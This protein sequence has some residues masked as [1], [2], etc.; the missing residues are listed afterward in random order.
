MDMNKKILLA[1]DEKR[2]VTLVKGCFE[3]A[4]LI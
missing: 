1:D 2:I 3:L 4:D